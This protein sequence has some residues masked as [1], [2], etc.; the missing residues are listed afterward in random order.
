MDEFMSQL[1][2]PIDPD[3]DSSILMRYGITK[4]AVIGRA[5]EAPRTDLLVLN[6]VTN[7]GCL[8]PP[9]GMA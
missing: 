7:R 9:R 4:D 6:H 8:W 3:R 2:D 5:G 1:P